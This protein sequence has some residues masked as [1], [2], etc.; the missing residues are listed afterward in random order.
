MEEPKDERPPYCCPCCKLKHENNLEKYVTHLRSMKR[1][2]DDALA[3][4]EKEQAAKE[5]AKQ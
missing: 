2:V 1:Q 3:K 4:A 5:K